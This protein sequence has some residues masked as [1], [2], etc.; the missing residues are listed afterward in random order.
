METGFSLYMEAVTIINHKNSCKS[1]N[2][3][4]SE[5]N[6]KDYTVIKVCH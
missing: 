3:I 5:I 6:S 2:L 1:K 4:N